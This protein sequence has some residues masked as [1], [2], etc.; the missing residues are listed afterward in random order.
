[1]SLLP[2][3][4][5]ST[6]SKSLVCIFL[7][8]QSFMY[9]L[10]PPQKPVLLKNRPTYVRLSFSCLIHGPTLIDGQVGHI[11]LALCFSEAAITL[12]QVN[13]KFPRPAPPKRTPIS[14]YLENL[15]YI[16]AILPP[17]LVY[18]IECFILLTKP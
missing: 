12:D 16:Y 18:F 2:K 1:M 17:S 5:Q 10:I 15:G 3:L 8:K 7:L 6:A 11:S 4:S 13:S 14:S 9:F